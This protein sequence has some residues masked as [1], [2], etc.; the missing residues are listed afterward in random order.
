MIVKRQISLTV[1][2]VW[3]KEKHVTSSS[4]VG[5]GFQVTS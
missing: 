2:V 5:F 1:C 4:V 3:G